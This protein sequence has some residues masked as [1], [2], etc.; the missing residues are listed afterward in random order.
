MRSRALH[1]RDDG[2]WLHLEMFRNLL[3]RPPSQAQPPH[4]PPT[5]IS[6][7]PVVTALNER[8]FAALRDIFPE[9]SLFQT[10]VALPHLRPTMAATRQAAFSKSGFKKV[11]NGYSLFDVSDDKSINFASLATFPTD[12]DLTLAYGEA[13]EENDMLWSLLNVNIRC[14]VD[15]PTVAS[16]AAPVSD[17]ESPEHVG[18][19]DKMNDTELPEV[20]AT[21]PRAEVAAVAQATVVDLGIGDELDRALHAVQDVCGLRKIVDNLAKID[22]LPELEDPAQLEQCR[23]DIAKLIK[24]TPESVTSLLKDLK[25][26]FG[27]SSGPPTIVGMGSTSSLLDVTASDLLPLVA[28]RERHQTEHARKGVRNYQP[29]HWHAQTQLASDSA[30]LAPATDDIQKK[31]KSKSEPTERRLLAQH[32]QAVMCSADARK[33]TTG[34]NRKA[35]TERP[36][37]AP[38]EDAKLTGNAANAA[39]AAKDRADDGESD[40]VTLQAAFV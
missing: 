5:L 17:A 20:N 26:S 16:I 12:A 27:P 24:M 6:L 4:R 39:L 9:M 8:V 3:L 1:C 40:V 28:I 19:D 31:D 11:A 10:I 2:Q 23:K 7:S 15:T 21:G 18:E 35:I 38:Q 34:L 22:D 37:G 13:Y 30:A 14:L 29:P 25:A 33:A 36:E 32:L